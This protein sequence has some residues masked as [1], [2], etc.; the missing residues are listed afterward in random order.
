GAPAFPGSLGV[1]AWPLLGSP[2]FVTPG[3]LC[4]QPMPPTVRT[5][6]S[7]S[8]VESFDEFI[9]VVVVYCAG[10]AAGAASGAG[11]A[12]VDGSVWA[13]GVKRINSP[14][15]FFAHTVSLWPD[16]AGRSSP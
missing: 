14:R 10:A 7:A 2:R 11:V 9:S 5:N 1:P 16:S 3:G 15:R 6:A 8:R 4:L 13:G 12:V